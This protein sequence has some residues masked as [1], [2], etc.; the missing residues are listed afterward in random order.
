MAA[1]R[2][3][4]SIVVLAGACVIEAEP[5]T[6]TPPCGVVVAAICAIATRGATA[7]K[8]SAVEANSAP[9]KSRRP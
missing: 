2:E 8:T 5:P 4:W 6:T 7:G 1:R 9:R 3:D